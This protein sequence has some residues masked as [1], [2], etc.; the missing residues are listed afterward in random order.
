MKANTTYENEAPLFAAC[1]WFAAANK[2]AEKKAVI[3]GMCLINL[4][5]QTF[6]ALIIN[7]ASGLQL[8]FNAIFLG[9][10]LVGLLHSAD[11]YFIV[12]MVG[13]QFAIN[14]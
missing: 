4:F 9:I 10:L 7:K 8:P 3:I 11:I 6:A 14:N 5:L 1:N 12:G 2:P 13:K